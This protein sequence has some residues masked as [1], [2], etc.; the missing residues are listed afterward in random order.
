VAS[1]IQEATENSPKPVLAT[2]MGV[3]GTLALN[4]VPSYM[5]PESAAVALA[6]VTSYG[7]WLRKPDAAPAGSTGIDRDA[8]K[9][10]VTRALALGGGWLEPLAAQ[11]LLQTCGINCADARTARSADQAARAAVD[12]GFPVALKALGETLLHKTEAGGVRLGLVNEQ[13]VREAHKDLAL[14]LGQRLDGVLVQRMVTGGI[15]M[16]AGALNDPSFGP[17]VMAGTGGI[18]VELIAD[19]VFR[20][21]PLTDVD[22][23]EMIE[24]MKGRVLLRGY[25]GA[26]RADEAALRGVLV[27]ISQLVDACP[28][29][30]EMDINPLIV[31]ARGAVAADVRIRVGP[32]AAG[33]TGRRV[34]Y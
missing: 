6:R 12:I 20:M 1:A 9:A 17:V 23:G 16:V 32:R 29:I 27:T 15:E 22:A 7:E 33:P 11:E 18:F 5:F 34:S 10:I 28:E 24:E 26:P 3:Q 30:L 21:A 25:R 31:S 19:T 4:S 8:A 2:F 14:R 13:A